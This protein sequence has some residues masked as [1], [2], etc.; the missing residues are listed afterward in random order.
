MQ[1]FRRSNSAVVSAAGPQCFSRIAM[2]LFS[3]KQFSGGQRSWTA[4]L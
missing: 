1:L 3:Q 2:Q 4:V